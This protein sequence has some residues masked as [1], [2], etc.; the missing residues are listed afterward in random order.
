ML[1]CGELS[2]KTSFSNFFLHCVLFVIS[3]ILSWE[4]DWGLEKGS[5]GKGVLF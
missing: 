1:R 4:E 3:I 5:F 2:P